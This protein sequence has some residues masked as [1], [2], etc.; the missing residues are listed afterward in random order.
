MGEFAGLSEDQIAEL[1]IDRLGLVVL[2]DL[3]TT[4][5]W[6]SYNFLN[7]VS[8]IGLGIPAQ[9][10]LAEALN[11]LVA[12][13]MVAQGTPGQSSAQAIFITRLGQEVLDNGLDQV[14]AAERLHLD[15][16]DRLQPVRSQFLLGEYE[17]AAF[18]AMRGVEIRVRELSSLGS[19]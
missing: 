4:G 13:G 14:D 7:R 3:A 18:A 1:P 12:R 19:R 2:G 10:C 5:E 11:W 9:R 6:N 8:Q 15:L 17:L 16:H